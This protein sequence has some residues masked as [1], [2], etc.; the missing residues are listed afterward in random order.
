MRKLILLAVVVAAGALRFSPAY[1]ET[2]A[3]IAN[4]ENELSD[5]PAQELTQIYQGIKTRWKDGSNIFVINRS[6]DSKPRQLFYR[7]ALGTEPAREF[8]LI[9]TPVPFKSL[10]QKT[11][12][13]TKRLVSR[14]PNAIGYI[15]LH[16]LD[17]TVKVLSVSGLHPEDKGY[18][19]GD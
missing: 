7:K 9:G 8:Y 12:L 13:S 15:D 5:I 17:S 3:V 16:E 19:L 10:I 1:A 14:T 11:D 2:V 18:L 6:V 4:Q